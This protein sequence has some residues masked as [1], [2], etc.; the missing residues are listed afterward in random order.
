[1]KRR[2]GR[3]LPKNPSPPPLTLVKIRVNGRKRRKL[4]SFMQISFLNSVGKRRERERKILFSASVLFFCNQPKNPTKKNPSLPLPLP[5]PPF[6]LCNQSLRRLFFNPFLA[7]PPSVDPKR[8]EEKRRGGRSHHLSR[9][10]PPFSGS[11][12]SFSSSSAAF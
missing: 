7:P 4:T 2:I 11:K 12:P 10:I 5:P 8:R 6:S 3:R 1:M 9:R